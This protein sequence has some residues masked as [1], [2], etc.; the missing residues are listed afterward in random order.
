MKQHMTY[1]ITDKELQTLMR[2]ALKEVVD[3]TVER[4]RTEIPLLAELLKEL[5]EIIDQADRRI[6]TRFESVDGKTIIEQD[7]TIGRAREVIR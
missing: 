7:T 6:T 5:Q 2:L 3:Q 4:M 1:S